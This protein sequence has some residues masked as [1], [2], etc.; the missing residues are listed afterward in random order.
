MSFLRQDA[1]ESA[2]RQDDVVAE[3]GKVLKCCEE[4]FYE[5]ECFSWTIP[6]V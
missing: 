5:L 6:G 2:S 1:V 3:G 4:T